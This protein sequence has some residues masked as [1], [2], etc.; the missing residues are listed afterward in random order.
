MSYT[1]R[2]DR[3]AE[4]EIRNLDTKI[5]KRILAALHDLEADPFRRGVKKLKDASDP[6]RYRVGSYRILFTIKGKQLVVRVVGVRHR[7][8]AYHG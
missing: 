2:I 7:S 3:A 5:R 6:Y 4:K 8:K 1:V